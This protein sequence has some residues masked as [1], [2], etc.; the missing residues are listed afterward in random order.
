MSTSYH[1]LPQSPDIPQHVEI[2]SAVEEAEMAEEDIEDSM[3]DEH[4]PSVSVPV[5]PRIK[6]VHFMLGSAVLL[7]WNGASRASDKLVVIVL[8]TASF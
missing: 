5:D 7:P 6:W 4:M 8:D 3:I 2:P 1:A